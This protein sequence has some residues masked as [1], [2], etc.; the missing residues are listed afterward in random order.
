MKKVLFSA[1]FMLCVGFA[2]SAQEKKVVVAETS[3]PEQTLDA[4]VKVKKRKTFDAR[5]K[6][7]IARKKA[8]KVQKTTRTE[9]P[10]AAR[11]APAATAAPAN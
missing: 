7:V 11:P 5:D 4:P 3:T 6:K 9:G 2:A 1:A 10:R 8:I